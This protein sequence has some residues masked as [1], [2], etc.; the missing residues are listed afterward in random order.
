MEMTPGTPYDSMF[1]PVGRLRC[2]DCAAHDSSAEGRATSKLFTLVYQLAGYR[3]TP[4]HLAGRDD[5]IP[6]ELDL[7]AAYYAAYH[8][9]EHLSYAELD[10]EETSTGP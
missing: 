2:E 1:D 5:D 4:E 9:R 10:L 3:A 6:E 7:R 8:T